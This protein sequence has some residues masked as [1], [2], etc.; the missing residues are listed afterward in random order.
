[1]KYLRQTLTYT[2]LSIVLMIVGSIGYMVSEGWNFMG[3]LVGC[4]LNF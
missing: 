1:M 2:A 3:V 4:W